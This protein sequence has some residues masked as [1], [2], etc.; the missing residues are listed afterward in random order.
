MG[1]SDV[2]GG[3]GVIGDERWHEGLSA[4]TKEGGKRERAR[5]LAWLKWGRVHAAFG[6][7]DVWVRVKAGI[8]SG[9]W[10]KE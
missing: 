7:N 2:F 8:E 5:C 6:A 4:G 9:Q 3:G 1:E 10:P